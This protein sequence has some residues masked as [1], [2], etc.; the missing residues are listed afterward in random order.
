MRWSWSRCRLALSSRLWAKAL[1]RS[2]MF[3]GLAW[4]RSIFVVHRNLQGAEEAVVLGSQFDFPGGF[5]Y[6]LRGRFGHLNVFRLFF[7]GVLIPSVEPD[8]R[9][10][11]QEDV[12]AGFLD[13]ADR[14]R[15]PGGLGEGIVDRV[16]QFLHEALQ[17]FFHNSSLITGCA[18]NHR[19]STYGPAST[20]R[21]DSD[22]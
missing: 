21:F 7:V 1:R 6:G 18:G 14:F 12:V 13:F 22:R 20:T 15:D 17:G 8:G 16:S 5:E 19:R 2:S 11:H 4:M 9:F 10:Q 3:I